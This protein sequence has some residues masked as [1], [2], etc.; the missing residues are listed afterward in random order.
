MQSRRTNLVCLPLFDQIDPRATKLA[1]TYSLSQRKL[2][3]T[4]Y[5]L[6]RSTYSD[7]E[8]GMVLCTNML[9]SKQVLTLF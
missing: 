9:R 3:N 8:T 6:L 7:I 1:V 4:I 2:T 5:Y